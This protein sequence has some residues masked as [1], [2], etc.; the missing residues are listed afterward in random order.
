MMYILYV[1]TPVLNGVQEGKHKMSPQ[2]KA[3]VFALST[4]SYILSLFWWLFW[5]ISPVALIYVLLSIQVCW[6][7]T[8]YMDMFLFTSF[9]EDLGSV[10]I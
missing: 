8:V 2:S 5:A 1:P 3:T 10:V 9:I 7:N 4:T 6:W